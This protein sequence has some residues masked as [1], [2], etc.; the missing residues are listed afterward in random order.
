M[1]HIKQNSAGMKDPIPAIGC[2]FRSCGLIAEYKT[3]KSLTVEQL[4]GLWDW[5]KGTGRIDKNDC[6]RDSASIATRALR[7]LGDGG[8]FIEVGLFRDGAT[9]YYSAYN[10]GPLAR[11]DA[12]IQKCST[13]GPEGTHYRVVTKK[14][15]LI[16]DPHEPEIRIRGVIYSILYAYEGGKDE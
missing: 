11:A 2:F 3:Q 7:I 4:N 8:R 15:F 5:A 6:V 1:I 10:G 12:L 13:S 16:E 14:G 9:S